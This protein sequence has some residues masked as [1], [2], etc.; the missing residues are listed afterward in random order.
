MAPEKNM[1]ID[2]CIIGKKSPR[3]LNHA[4]SAG[5]AWHVHSGQS[6]Q[7]ARQDI[8]YCI[9][10]IVC[11]GVDFFS[12]LAAMMRVLAEREPKE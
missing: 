2:C 1:R 9:V 6:T 5:D 12:E 8:V 3:E 4:S 7:L 10:S 11:E